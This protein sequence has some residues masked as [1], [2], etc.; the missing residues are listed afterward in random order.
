MNRA[1]NAYA[2]TAAMGQSGRETESFVL[3]NAAARLQAIMDAWEEKSQDLG[4]ALTYN[5]RIWTVLATGVTADENQLPDSVKQ[6]ILNLALFIF[7]RTIDTEVAPA[8]HKLK[9]LISIN[10]EIA[11]GLRAIPMPVQAEKAA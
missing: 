6:S 9:S 7:K 8:P 4:A 1:A 5:R 2:R 10:R 3:L 11:A